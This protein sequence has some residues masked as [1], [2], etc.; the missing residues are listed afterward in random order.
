MNKTQINLKEC[1]KIKDIVEHALGIGYK[2]R[3][4]D[5]V[6]AKKVYCQVCKNLG[7]SVNTFCKPINIDHTTGFHHLA[8]MLPDELT[9]AD[10][11]TT[12][13]REKKQVTE[14][15]QEEKPIIV[16]LNAYERTGFRYDQGRKEINTTFNNV[17]SLKGLTII[18]K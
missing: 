18:L 12:K 3:T 17:R 11:I 5:A 7:Y 6:K 14:L 16:R 15:K 4:K 2:G 10:K 9:V 13:I 1:F 8:R